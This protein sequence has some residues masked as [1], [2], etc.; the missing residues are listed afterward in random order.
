[1]EVGQNDDTENHTEDT[2][3]CNTPPF[4]YLPPYLHYDYPL[5]DKYVSYNIVRKNWW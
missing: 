1:M 3:F 2:I 5:Q 4:P